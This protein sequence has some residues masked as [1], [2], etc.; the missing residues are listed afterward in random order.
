MNTTQ[1]ASHALGVSD[2]RSIDKWVTYVIGCT[3]PL[4]VMASYVSS[5]MST[6]WLGFFRVVLFVIVLN[7]IYVSFL[8]G[9]DADVSN[10]VVQYVPLM[11][12]SLLSIALAV[13]LTAVNVL[14]LAGE[15]IA[16]FALTYLTLSSLHLAANLTVSTIVAAMFLVLSK[17]QRVRAMVRALCNA[18]IYT[19]VL[20]VL[21]AALFAPEEQQ[22]A[23]DGGRNLLLVC[24]PRCPVITTETSTL[25]ADVVLWIF[26]VAI[27][28]NICGVV[29][30]LCVWGR[31]RAAESKEK[32][33][34]Q[35]MIKDIAALKVAYARV[36]TRPSIQ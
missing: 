29:L 14:S 32:N 2:C 18:A 13:M 26:V 25:P 27:A 8:G 34:K 3:V 30:F 20:C 17:S 28:T 35:R 19:V 31:R 5:E 7:H 33:E 4:L 22:S 1:V 12:S 15:T 6:S 24:E 11:L 10:S 16:L 23:C 9:P 21:A 36:P